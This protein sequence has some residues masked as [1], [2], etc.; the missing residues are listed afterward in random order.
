VLL[1]LR[2]NPGGALDSALQIAG[3]FA[4]KVPV[5]AMQ[6]SQEIRK[7]SGTRAALGKRRIAVIVDE[8]TASA[9]ELLATALASVS[10]A[11]VIGAPTIGKCLVH[12]VARL[13]DGGLLLFTVGRLRSL[14]GRSLC[15]G[16][17]V[18]VPERGENEQLQAGLRA[19]SG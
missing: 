17:H 11:K 16:V 3:L 5:A 7:L 13:D 18:D 19:L 2:D 10:S 9:A 15:D 1:D 4:G 14:E 8:G 12:S 6:R